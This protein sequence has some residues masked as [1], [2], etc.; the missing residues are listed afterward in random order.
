[1][2]RQIA[3]LIRSRKWEGSGSNEVVFASTS[4]VETA[5]PIDLALAELVL[6]AAFVRPLEGEADA[7]EPRLIL[8][9]FDVTLAAAVAGG[10][11]GKESLAGGSRS[12]G[13]GASPGRGVLELENEVLATLSELVQTAGLALT[14]RSRGPGDLQFKGDAGFVTT[15]SLVFEAALLAYRYYHPPLNLAATG[16]AGQAVLT[17]T[18]GPDRYDR[19]AVVLRRASGSTPPATATA[20]TGVTLGSALA[21]GVTNTGLAAGTYSYA[22]F[23]AYDE[24]SATP[25]TADR[26]SD[27]EPS[28]VATVVVT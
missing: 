22:A 12:G 16:G 18:V 17:W 3:Y 6:P 28:A 27:Q 2:A 20:G 19:L 25:T 10:R 7:T 1:M 21:T 11:F 5:A 15:R 23:M 13:Q 14:L 4:V 9:R 24:T 8:E 26:Y